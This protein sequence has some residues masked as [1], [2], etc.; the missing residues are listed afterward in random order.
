MVFYFI[1]VV[2]SFNLLF[3]ISLFS[4]AELGADFNEVCGSHKEGKKKEK[5]QSRG[6]TTWQPSFGRS[7]FGTWSPQRCLSS[8]IIHVNRFFFFF[9][10]NKR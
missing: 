4:S 2:F 5:H 1:L 10:E 7:D 9:T 8:L 3:F 6:R